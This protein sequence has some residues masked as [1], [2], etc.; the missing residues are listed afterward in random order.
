MS[1]SPADL[2]AA[3]QK[4]E[5]LTPKERRSVIAYLDETDQHASNYELARL[6]QCDE[7]AIRRD[8]ER[9]LRRYASHINPKA[10]IVYVAKYTKEHDALIRSAKEGLRKQTAGT[11][12]HQQY[13]RLVS[14]LEERRIAKLQSIGIVP[15]ELGAQTV[16]E[17]SWV[18]EFTDDGVALVHQ[19]DGSTKQR[20]LEE[21]APVDDTPND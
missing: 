9:L 16:S 18:A 13:L 8:K 20:H 1:K 4:G 7:K 6:F 2:Y 11:A 15:K 17:E 12:A 19:D 10:A 14:D 3:A 21:G 5:R